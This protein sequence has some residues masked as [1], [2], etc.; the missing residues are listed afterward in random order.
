MADASKF[1]LMIA[2]LLLRPRGLLGRQWREIRNETLA[3]VPGPHRQS[4]FL[5]VLLIL[6]YALENLKST[7]LMASQILILPWSAWVSISSLV[8]RACSPSAMDVL[9]H[10]MFGATLAQLHVFK[11]PSQFR[12]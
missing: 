4:V 3:P 12:S 6:P 9:R 1:A 8:T 10:G 2:I 11:G 5:G 7:A